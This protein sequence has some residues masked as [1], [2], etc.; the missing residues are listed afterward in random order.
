MYD[1]LVDPHP[2]VTPGQFVR[3]GFDNGRVDVGDGVPDFAGPPPPPSPKI[4]VRFEGNDVI[5]EWASKEFYELQDGTE[6]YSGSESFIDPFS[7]T[8]DF[9]SYTVKVSPNSN[10]SNF[11]DLLT[12]DNINYA[13][14]NVADVG[15]FLDTPILV[16]SLLAN[17]EDYPTMFAES[18][19]IWELVPFGD[20]RSLLENHSVN[21]IFEFIS[22][23]VS[24]VINGTETVD[25]NQYS[26]RLFNKYLE[27]ISYVS[28][29]SS[30]FGDPRTGTPPQTSSYMSNM[31]KVKGGNEGEEVALP[32]KTELSQN[33]PNPFNPETKINFSLSNSSNVKLNIYNVTGQLVE[34]L[35][36]KKLT[37]GYHSKI[38]KA[39]KLNSGI[40]Y[41]TLKADGKKISKKMVLV[42]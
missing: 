30:D 17:P 22:T 25:Y 2:E 8:R 16:D 35:I 42:K 36:D 26:L 28:V 13:Y 19:K 31:K 34:K 33:Y 9:E 5:V 41:Y 7:R 10:V 4:E 23:P 24:V 20:N 37:A 32:F 1:N 12:I 3:Y 38:F 29:V 40:Y 6:S 11:I 27:N 14:Q 15:D 39:D 21:S 18:G